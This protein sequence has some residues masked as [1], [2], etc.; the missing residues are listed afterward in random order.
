MPVKTAEKQYFQKFATQM[1]E[2]K[3]M[4][5]V[6]YMED[7]LSRIEKGH[8]SGLHTIEHLWMGVILNE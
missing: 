5:L 8:T 4:H 6:R 7:L 1:N 2:D 3:R